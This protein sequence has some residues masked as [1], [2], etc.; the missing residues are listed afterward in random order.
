[1]LTFT[2]TP[3]LSKCQHIFLKDSVSNSWRSQYKRCCAQAYKQVENLSIQEQ[4]YSKKHSNMSKKGFIKSISV[5]AKNKS[6]PTTYLISVFVFTVLKQL[7]TYFACWALMPFLN[8]LPLNWHAAQKKCLSALMILLHGL[9]FW[10]DTQPYS[11]GGKT[12]ESV[13]S[14]FQVMA[15]IVSY[16]RYFI[17]ENHDQSTPRT[18]VCIIFYTK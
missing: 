8:R 17:S 6:Q 9:K 18:G 10:K 3:K 2:T 5:I 1:M 11:H 7:A 12:E 13:V 15:D 14:G 4:I 16:K